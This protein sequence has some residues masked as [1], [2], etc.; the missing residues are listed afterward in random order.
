MRV[1]GTVPVQKLSREG[2]TTAAKKNERPPVRRPLA[3]SGF[4][5]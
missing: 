3:V 4:S 5:N 2:F 1:N